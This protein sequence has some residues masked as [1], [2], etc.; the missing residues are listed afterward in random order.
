MW[1]RHCNSAYFF[2]CHSPEIKKL[3]DGREVDAYLIGDCQ[4]VLLSKAQ[5][6]L[7]GISTDGCKKLVELIC[8]V[9]QIF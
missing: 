3:I 2:T 1:Q 4:V 8:Y 7:Y 9:F 5:G 6:G